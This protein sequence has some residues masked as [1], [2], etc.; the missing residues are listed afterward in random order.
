MH[1][2]I[3]YEARAARTIPLGVDEGGAV[4]HVGQQCGPA[5]YSV[6]FCYSVLSNR[7]SELWLINTRSG[8][9]ILQRDRQRLCLTFS[10]L[11]LVG[12]LR[13]CQRNHAAHYSP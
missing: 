1:S 3:G 10:T 8:K 5:L 4:I 2:V 9:R 6:L 7:R 11:D 13:R 12:S